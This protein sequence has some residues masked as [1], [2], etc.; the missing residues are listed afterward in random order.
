MNKEKMSC[1]FLQLIFVSRILFNIFAVFNSVNYKA[2]AE[3]QQKRNQ[4]YNKSQYTANDNRNAFFALFD[5]ALGLF[6]FLRLL[7]LLALFIE[8]SYRKY[9]II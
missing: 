1:K 7:P 6:L 2:Y 3:N 8:R 9:G 4:Q 5:V